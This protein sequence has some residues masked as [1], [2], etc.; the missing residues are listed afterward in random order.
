MRN[1]GDLFFYNSQGLQSDRRAADRLDSFNSRA[2][3]GLP[4]YTYI[5]IGVCVYVELC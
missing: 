4:G 3:Q 5:S 2:D 1:S